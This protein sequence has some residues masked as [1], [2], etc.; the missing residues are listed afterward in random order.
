[1]RAAIEEFLL[2]FPAL[3]SIV[4]PVSGALIFHSATA[5]RS[6]A[7]RALMSR[8]VAFYALLVMM[9]ALWAGSYVLAFFGVTLSALRCAGGLVVALSAWELLNRPEERETRKQEQV[10]G[11]AEPAEASDI[12][13]F[14]LTIP[15]TTGPG[16]MAV[17]IA[18]SA[19]HPTAPKD[20]AAFFVGVSAAAM[21][22]SG[23]IWGSYRAAETISRWLGPSGSRT[24]SRLAA[25]LL[26]CVG[27]QIL[28][29]GV[30]GVLAP[31]LGHPA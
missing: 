13:L 18:L 27:I 30:T 29:T 10:A 11:A 3:F 5:G 2:A 8:R 26:L 14:P 31:L 23:V 24:V 28:I 7:E 17:A 21:A 22:L 15:F 20:L 25:F 4:N 16:T 6:H 12:T 1:M 9:V 19:G